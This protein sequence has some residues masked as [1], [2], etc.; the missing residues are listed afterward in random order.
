VSPVGTTEKAQSLIQSSLRDSAIIT[1]LFPSNKLLGYYHA[2]LAGLKMKG[3]IFLPGSKKK[4][5]KWKSLRLKVD[6]VSRTEEANG[7]ARRGERAKD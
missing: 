6:W 1:A 2:P 7:A 4:E 5:E 3:K